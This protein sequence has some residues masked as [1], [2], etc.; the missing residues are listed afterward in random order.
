MGPRPELDGSQQQNSFLPAHAIGNCLLLESS[1]NISKGKDELETFL[2]KVHEFQSE[3]VKVDQWCDAL[4]ITNEL[5]RPTAHSVESLVKAVAARTDAIK[6]ELL[7]YVEGRR[8]RKDWA[9]LKLTHQRQRSANVGSKSVRSSEFKDLAQLLTDAS[10]F[11][12]IDDRSSQTLT[13]WR[14]NLDEKH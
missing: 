10:D 9:A 5:R 13:R 3:Q 11:L 8:E 1:F 2:N 14:A 6:S 4:A 12:L 7:D